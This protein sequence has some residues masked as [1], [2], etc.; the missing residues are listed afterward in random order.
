MP[1]TVD[2]IRRALDKKF[3]ISEDEMKPLA[4]TYADEVSRVNDRLDEAVDLIRKGLRSEAIQAVNRT[5]N[6]MQ[7]A[8]ELEFPEADEW[9]EILQFMGLPIP[10]TLNSDA[11]S[12]VNDAI[13]DSMPLDALMRRHRQLAIAKAPL[14]MRLRVLRQIARR[15]DSNPVW[16][17]DIESWEKERVREI[18]HELDRAIEEEDIRTVCAIHQELT[19]SKWIAKPPARLVEQATFVAEGHYQM[20]SEKE[21]SLIADKLQVAF[22]KADEPGVRKYARQWQ[23]RRKELKRAV[24]SNLEKQVA[25]VFAWLTEMDRKAKTASKLASAVANLQSVM[26]SGGSLE[27]VRTAHQEATQLGE[28]LPEDVS[29]RYR[30]LLTADQ[31]KKKLKTGLIA[32]A[33]LI[34][35]IG[36]IALVLKFMNSGRQNQ[37]LQSAVSQMQTLVNGENWA[38]AQSFYERLERNQPNVASDPKIQALYITVEGKLNQE[39]EREEEFQRFLAQANNE[40]PAKIDEDLLRRARAKAVTDA[41]LAAVEKIRKRKEAYFNSTASEK[42]EKA[43]NELAEYRSELSSLKSRPSNKENLENVRKFYGRLI[44]LTQKHP[45]TL[46]KFNNEFQLLKQQ[47]S[48]TIRNIEQQMGQTTD[49]A[50]DTSLLVRSKSL[51]EYA[52]SLRK[53]S[54]ESTA[55]GTRQELLA[56]AKEEQQWEAVKMVNAWLAGI[57]ADTSEGI[58]PAE[59]RDI[60]KELNS[61]E[62]KVASIPHLARLGNDKQRLEETTRRD[63]LLNEVIDRLKGSPFTG[64]VELRSIDPTQGNSELRYYVPKRVIDEKPNLLT[65]AGT[66]G[67]P[68]VDTSLGAV[69]NRSFSGQRSTV[70]EPRASMQELITRIERRR[71]NFLRNWER[72]FV[73]L[74]GSVTKRKQLDGLIQENLVASLISDA[75]AGSKQFREATRQTRQELDLRQNSR[76][77]WYKARAPNSEL[78]SSVRSITEDELM[79]IYHSSDKQWSSLKALGESQIQWIGFLVRNSDGNM[80]CIQRGDSPTAD[81]D[82]YIAVEEKDSTRTN[83]VRIGKYI[84]ASCQL[85]P[86]RLNLVP[87]R[88]VFYLANENSP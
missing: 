67:I 70:D 47:T 22:E 18:D 66:V 19:A 58:T 24:S 69:R 81:G 8:L 36:V 83:I 65:V 15:D 72:E 45:G 54:G 85:E 31:K 10:P 16:F 27:D 1:S 55:I 40:D 32:G 82:L 11:V 87:G 77:Q 28:P 13:V 30:K 5:P 29:E 34:A 20:E 57:A 51:D 61:L 14:A 76:D 37:V 80:R 64:L 62:S 84:N 6:A 7:A 71:I 4:A 49:F 79:G 2:K 33:V 68:V 21:L 59:S 48:S 73:E 12:Q 56:S 60:L 23:S 42:T 63:M 86:S 38:Q 39:D 17:E 3:G 78:K 74:I 25:P 46:P 75:V 44:K 9:F 43:L 26:D 52:D 35:V 50:R 41:E 88:P 53:I